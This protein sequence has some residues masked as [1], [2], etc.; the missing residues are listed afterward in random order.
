MCTKYPCEVTS[1]ALKQKVSLAEFGGPEPL[2][3]IDV[4]SG[5][6]AP[7]AVYL[8]PRLMASAFRARLDEYLDEQ[9][10]VD[11]WTSFFASLEATPSP[12]QEED[13][14]FA[15]RYRRPLPSNAYTPRREGRAGKRKS[16]SPSLD[17]E[18]EFAFISSALVDSVPTDLSEESDAKRLKTMIGA[19]GD[20]VRNTDALK[21][22]VTFVNSFV[23]EAHEKLDIGL[24]DAEFATAVLATKVGDRPPSLGTDSVFQLL[25]DLVQDVGS[26]HRDV[27]RMDSPEFEA[28]RSQRVEQAVAEDV[29]K[30]LRPFLELFKMFSRSFEAP[31]DILEERLR[32]LESQLPVG[33]VTAG[34]P[35][36]GPWFGGAFPSAATLQTSNVGRAAGGESTTELEAR[37]NARLRALEEQARDMQEEMATSSVKIGIATFASRSHTKAWMDTNGCPTRAGLYFLDAMSVLALMHNGS[38]S[39]KT[40]AEFASVT[41]KVGYSSPDEALVVT[42]F[43]LELPEAFGAL[44]SSGVA[45]DSRLLPALPTFKEWDGGNGYNGLKHTIADKLSEFSRHMS[46]HYRLHLVGEGLTV[47]LQ[48]L[49]TSVTFILELSTWINHKYQDTIARTTASEKEAWALIA[50][51]VRVIFKLLRDARSSGLRWTPEAPE[52]DV[53]LVWAQLQCHRAMA[54]LQGVGFSAHPALSHVLNLHLQ[55]NVASRSKFEALEKRVGEAERIAKDAK[56]AAEKR[57]GGNNRGPQAPAA[58]GAN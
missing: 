14:I 34:V 49:S 23:R 20:L 3:F 16:S 30:H 56:R 22:L 44:P 55:D 9:R 48:M 6:A 31:G 40:A 38:D 53:Q 12:T 35:A 43:S 52:G 5:K 7:T 29:A 47:A 50:H 24:A 26:L 1:H 41:K 19:W 39:A 21:R 4:P 17:E 33:R 51:C 2:V 46:S 32:A 11:Q 27:S 58:A 10:T 13:E 37:I 54:G 57:A 25:E 36:Q 18:D 28:A 45:R 42:S 15:Q 8:T